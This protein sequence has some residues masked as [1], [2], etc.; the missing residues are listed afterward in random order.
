MSFY[1]EPEFFCPECGER[2]CANWVD[3]GFGP[4]SCQASPYHCICGWVESGCPADTCIR[5]RCDSWDFC[6]GK[7]MNLTLN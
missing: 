4:Y 2:A 7:A 5:E 1:T 3:I 6:Q